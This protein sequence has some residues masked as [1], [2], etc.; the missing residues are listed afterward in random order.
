MA[1]S[2]FAV[3]AMNSNLINRGMLR[4]GSE[5][6]MMEAM[7]YVIHD[8]VHRSVLSGTHPFYFQ[9]RIQVKCAI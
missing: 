7:P 3:S 8:E 4:A 6:T 2:Q 1:D 5:I 9:D